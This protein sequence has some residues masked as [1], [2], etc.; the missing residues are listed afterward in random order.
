MNDVN[1][2]TID[3]SAG[4]VTGHYTVENRMV[5]VQYD[6]ASKSTQVGGSPPETVARF[7]LRDLVGEVAR[8]D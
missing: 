3:T 7:L 2:V 4:K 1:S 8:R 5:I 6:G